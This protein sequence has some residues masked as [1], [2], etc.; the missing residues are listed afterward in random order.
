MTPGYNSYAMK[1]HEIKKQIEEQREVPAKDY[2]ATRLRE[3]ATV[4]ELAREV[5]MGRTSLYY[6]LGI[7]GI[8]V[9][10]TVHVVGETPEV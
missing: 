1:W 5:G 6:R 10:R 8:S 2:L 7:L 4:A 9:E 3:G